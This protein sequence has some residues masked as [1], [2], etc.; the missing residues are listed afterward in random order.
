MATPRRYCRIRS[1]LATARIQIRQPLDASPEAAGYDEPQ[2][3]QPATTRDW[4]LFGM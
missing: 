4:L 3:D 1:C 2:H